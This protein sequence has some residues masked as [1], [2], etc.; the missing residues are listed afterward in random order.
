MLML[1]SG[2]KLVLSGLDWFHGGAQCAVMFEHALLVPDNL[3][4]PI[5]E[6]ASKQS[7]FCSLGAMNAVGVEALGVLMIWPSL[8]KLYAVLVVFLFVSLLVLYG[9]FEPGWP[10]V[11]CAL[12]WSRMEPSP[13]AT[14]RD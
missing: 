4:T 13:S 12:A 2:S 8:R 10:L 9:M 11:A 7:L 6:A 5:R 3:F 14:E 1:A